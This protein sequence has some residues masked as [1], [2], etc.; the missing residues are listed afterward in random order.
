MEAEIGRI[1]F[2]PRC[3]GFGQSGMDHCH[4]C[5]GTG[6][7]LLVGAQSFPNTEAGHKA[8]SDWRAK[9]KEEGNGP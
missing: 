9:Q 1:V 4:R 2:C 6:D 3:W 5:D 8:A 7:V